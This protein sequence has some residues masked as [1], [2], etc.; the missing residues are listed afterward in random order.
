M[1]HISPA[2]N[3][4]MQRSAAC[5]G[6]RPKLKPSARG[7]G[8]VWGK[9][10]GKWMHCGGKWGEEKV[11]WMDGSVYHE[12]KLRWKWVDQRKVVC[13]KMIRKTKVAHKTFW[14]SEWQTWVVQVWNSEEHLLFQ[15]E[16]KKNAQQGII[17]LQNLQSVN[18]SLWWLTQLVSN[19]ENFKLFYFM[20][21]MATI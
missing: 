1:E 6:N 4:G 3:A 16:K 8:G 7:G 14:L 21:T 9:H 2:H 11:S 10:S 20:G 5:R 18:R 17:E 13:K 19:A 12:E 15:T